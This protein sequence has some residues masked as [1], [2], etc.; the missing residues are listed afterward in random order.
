MTFVLELCPELSGGRVGWQH[1]GLAD[2]SSLE[3]GNLRGVGPIGRRQSAY[4]D[5]RL[6]R[7][8]DI[9]QPQKNG[10]ASK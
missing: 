10:T 3:Y 9:G 1:V 2:R 5:R 4:R 6:S 8:K 7:G